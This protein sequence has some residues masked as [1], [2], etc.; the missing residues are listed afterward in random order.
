[1]ERRN[2]DPHPD[3]PKA[4]PYIF[5]EAQV[6]EISVGVDLGMNIA[7]T[8]PT[9]CGK[10]TLPIAL[11]ATLG[12]PVIR[13]NCNGETRVSNMVGMN[14]P[15]LEEG[16]LTLRFSPAAL[17]KAMSEGYWTI[18][19]EIDAALPSVLFVLQPVL[20]EGCRSL[21]VPETGEV[22]VPAP[23]FQIFATGNTFGYRAMARAHY[24]G[25]NVLNDAFV[26]RFG[27][28]I[29]VNYPSEEQERKRIS[30]NCPGVDPLVV[31]GIAKVADHLRSEAGFS[32]DFSTRRCVQWARLVPEFSDEGGISGVMM[33]AECAV[34]R[35]LKN[36]TDAK[37]AR[38]VISRVFG[39]GGG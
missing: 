19:D 13:F 10:T 30:A 20:E 29:A 5:D 37:V 15:A 25:T 24:T 16:V 31:T 12:H 23:G 9:G 17:V 26:D 39:Y 3:C 34:L 32:S 7:L 4:R 33:A 2:G 28:V 18:F 38:E 11:A 22:V 35:K 27:I 6:K 21:H 8:G 1:M 36:P 14:R